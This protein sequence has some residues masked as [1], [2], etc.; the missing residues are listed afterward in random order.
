M[1]TNC[2]QNTRR[3][4][5]R[6]KSPHHRNQRT[7][8]RTRDYRNQ[9]LRGLSISGKKQKPEC[10][11]PWAATEAT[12]CK[13]HDTQTPEPCSRHASH[14]R[15]TTQ[16]TPPTATKPHQSS[17]HTETGR[18][19]IDQRLTGLILRKLDDSSLRAEPAAASTIAIPRQCTIQHCQR[20]RSE[21]RSESSIN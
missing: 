12:A 4:P 18:S 11:R 10:P 1:R 13:A 5:D 9:S 2:A 15:G 19:P 8:P 20:R 3:H 7:P 6:G 17:E 21:A 16:S 14:T